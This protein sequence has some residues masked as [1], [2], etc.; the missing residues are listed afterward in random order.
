LHASPRPP[1][2]AATSLS[3]PCSL[4]T[5]GGSPSRRQKTTR[6]EAKVKAPRTR[7]RCAIPCSHRRPG[8]RTRSAAEDGQFGSRERQGHDGGEPPASLS[9]SSATSCTLSH[10]IRGEPPPGAP[11]SMPPR[12]ARRS[13]ARLGGRA[14][15]EEVLTQSETTLDSVSDARCGRLCRWW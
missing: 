1:S 5:P 14:E 12:V 11:Y 6:A 13:P 7:R 8:R 9:R 10:L 3:R 2:C 4:P 15:Q